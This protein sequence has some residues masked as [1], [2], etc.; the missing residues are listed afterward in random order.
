MIEGLDIPRKHYSVIRTVLERR[1]GD[2]YGD[3]KKS[4]R[5]VAGG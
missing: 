1:L 3:G 2:R 5:D 4:P